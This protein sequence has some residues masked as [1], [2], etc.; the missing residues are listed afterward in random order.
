MRVGLNASYHVLSCC[1]FIFFSLSEFWNAL[2][3][4]LNQTR[5]CQT[6]S[7]QG[8]PQHCLPHMHS[9]SAFASALRILDIA[10]TI[11]GWQVQ[12]R[13]HYITCIIV[14][15]G[16]TLLIPSCGEEAK[17]VAK[18]RGM[19]SMWRVLPVGMMFLW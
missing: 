4:V 5:K 8:S 17:A 11:T 16:T 3:P 1:F 15:L 13:T 7:S 14:A 10:G 19:L 6:R 12:N 18:E 9:T 2:K